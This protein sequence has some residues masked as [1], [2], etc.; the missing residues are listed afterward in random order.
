M[1]AF[2]PRSNTTAE[3]GPHRRRFV[4]IGLILA[5]WTMTSAAHG[6]ATSARPPVRDG[7]EVGAD[8]QSR[9]SE[10]EN[11]A[12]EERLVARSKELLG[13]VWSPV[14]LGSLIGLAA[15]LILARRRFGAATALPLGVYPG[16]A[17]VLLAM[18]CY[19]AAQSLAQLLVQAFGGVDSE[20]AIPLASLLAQVGAIGLGLWL[21]RTGLR[22]PFEVLGVHGR[23]VGSAST[24]AVLIYLAQL[25]AFMGLIV[26]NNLL[27]EPRFQDQVMHIAEHDEGLYRGLYLVAVV[28]LAPLLEELVFRGLLLPPLRRRLGVT[29]GVVAS[30]LLFMLVHPPQT[31]LPIFWLGVVLGAAYHYTGNLVAPV[32]IHAVHNGV[33]FGLIVWL[34]SGV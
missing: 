24:I 9:T 2:M 10:S 13:R 29:G 7:S 22:R 8:V 15:L 11:S 27:I 30:A 6:A 1:D 32:L 5:C 4:I 33:Q 14:V 17:A 12:A 25:P 31:Y 23:N 19:L 21:F 34:T 28:I 16:L 18:F 3:P 26:V 20:L